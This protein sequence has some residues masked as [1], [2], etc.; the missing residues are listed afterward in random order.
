[1]KNDKYYLQDD[2]APAGA[3][4]PAGLLAA[5]EL[6]RSRPEPDRHLRQGELHL[7]SEG[8]EWGVEL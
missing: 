4:P 7:Y 2:P 3:A 5:A 1:M 8:E 6:P